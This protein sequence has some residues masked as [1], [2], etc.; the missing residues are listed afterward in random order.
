MLHAN[1]SPYLLITVLT[2]EHA[3][4][5]R[6]RRLRIPGHLGPLQEDVVGLVAHKH[7][8][9][10]TRHTAQS[11]EHEEQQSTPFYLLGDL[12]GQAKLLRHACHAMFHSLEVVRVADQDN[13][14]DVV[15]KQLPPIFP[16]RFP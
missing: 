12:N 8:H 5:D 7:H 11:G 10:H 9:T 6:V 4:G 3:S 1:L 16:F 2:Y 14:G 13:R 15:S